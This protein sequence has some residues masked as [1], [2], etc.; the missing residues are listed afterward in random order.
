MAEI[1][2]ANVDWIGALD[3][4]VVPVGLR[5]MAGQEAPDLAASVATIFHETGLVSSSTLAPFEREIFDLYHSGL[6]VD[7]IAHRLKKHPEDVKYDLE[8]AIDRP[9]FQL[10][11]KAHDLE[12]AVRPFVAAPR[13]PGAPLSEHEVRFAE[14]RERLRIGT[15]FLNE[16]HDLLCSGEKYQEEQANLIKEYRAGQSTFVASIAVVLAP[17][18]GAGVQ[19]VAAAVAVSLSVIGQIGLKAWCVAQAQRRRDQRP[20]RPRSAKGV[21][22]PDVGDAGS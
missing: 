14:G 17:Y 9:G 18:L 4:T 11:V 19:I 10:Y 12:R 8:F 1:V 13:A 3:N 21:E 5:R 6:T 16:L 2:D 15:A 22:D 20:T 7:E